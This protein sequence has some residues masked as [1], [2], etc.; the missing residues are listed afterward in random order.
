MASSSTTKSKMHFGLK[1][2]AYSRMLLFETKNAGGL[3]TGYSF[4]LFYSTKT[5]LTSLAHKQNKKILPTA[6][7]LAYK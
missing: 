6:Q 3:L 2:Q 7:N 1:C 5:R 4:N